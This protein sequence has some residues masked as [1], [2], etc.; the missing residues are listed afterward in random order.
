MPYSHHIHGHH[1]S[2]NVKI[3][4][5]GTENRL[6]L[7]GTARFGQS[8][9]E[10]LLYEAHL[11][12]LVQLPELNLCRYVLRVSTPAV[13]ASITKYKHEHKELTIWVQY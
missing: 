8:R 11:S 10:K 5:S 7:K 1:G 12:F 9:T 13:I 4:S 2:S 6:R 3:A